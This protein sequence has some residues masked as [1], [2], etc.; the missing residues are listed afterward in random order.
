LQQKPFAVQGGDTSRRSRRDGLI[1]INLR[2][3]DALLAVRG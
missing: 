1:A 2:D 3:D